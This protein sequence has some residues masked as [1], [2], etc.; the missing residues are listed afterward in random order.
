MSG[1]SP[2]QSNR[3]FAKQ[4]TTSLVLPPS[5]SVQSHRQF[6]MARSSR[7][8]LLE[9][10]LIA[11]LLPRPRFLSLR[12][13]RTEQ[14]LGTV[15]PPRAVFGV[16]VS[17]YF[18]TLS[19]TLRIHFEYTSNT[20]RIHTSSTLYHNISLTIRFKIYIYICTYSYFSTS[21]PYQGRLRVR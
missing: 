15:S 7:Q 13:R 4:M 18:Y 11:R 6:P 1:S 12:R 9:R 21:G 3:I 17:F 5:P 20:L 19:N 2:L 10:F 16:C 14:A 8:K